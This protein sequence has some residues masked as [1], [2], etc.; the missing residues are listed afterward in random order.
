I[1]QENPSGVWDD[2]FKGVWHLSEDPTGTIYD[3]TLNNNDGT[4]YGSM[5]SG[6]QVSGKIDGSLEFDGD[7]DYIDCGNDNSL[8]ITGDITIEF[9]VNGTSFSNDL[10]PDIL[11]KGNYTQAYST[12]IN[13]D[14]AV[15]FQLNG[16]SFYSTS[17]L[18]L[19]VWHS[20]VCVRNGSD[21]IIY[22]NGNED[23][24]D[25]FSSA[26]E[27]I[28]ETLTIAR[29]PDNL[30]GTLD[31][32]RLS[33]IARSSDWIATEYNNQYN[34]SN[35]S[36]IGTEKT[37]LAH[38]A[39]YFAYYKVITI[40][41]TKVSGSSDLINFPILLSIFDS[42]LH[43]H[44]QVDGDDIAFYSEGKWLDHEIEIFNHSFS[45]TQ[46]HLVTWIR[47]P[48]LSSSIDTEIRMY[49]GNSTMGSQENSNGVWDPNFVGVW[50]LNESGTGTANEYVD[51]GHYGNHGQGGL[52]NVSY[53]P[54][55]TIG[56]I[57]FGQDF[58]DNFIDCGN[59]TS[60]DIT[61]NQITMQLW[62]KYPATHPWMG[63]FNH[64]GYNEGYRLVIDEN[65]Q[66]LSFQLP[67]FESDLETSQ[68]IST[69]EW[70]YVVATYNGS[71]MR[72]YID[73]IPDP[74]NLTK[75]NN[76][77]TALP[78]PFRI[79]HGDHPE[80]VPWSYPWLGQIDEVRIS[81]IGRSA[82]WIATEYNN[83]Y[84]PNS[85]YTIGSQIG[86]DTTPPD[87]TINSPNPNE[88]FGFSAP[89]YNLTVIDA[90]LDS[91]WYSLNGGS[92]STPVGAIGAVD[93]TMWDT[94]GNGTVTIRFYAN[95]TL[96]YLNYDEVTVRKDIINPSIIIN[97][98]TSGSNHS[99]PPSYSL[100]ITEA[101][102]DE[103]WYTLDGGLNN[104]TGAS[105]GI[106]DSTAWGNAGLGA[107]TITF[108]VNDSV[109]N[110]N[111]TS[112]GITKTSDLS[113]SINTP[114]TDEWF[115]SN[116]D[117]EVDVSGIDRNSIWY[118]IDN[119]VN[120][121]TIT[122]NANQ[123]STWFGAIDSTAWGNADEGLITVKFYLNN[124]FGMVISDS[125][126]INKDSI[127][128]SINNINSPLP[129]AWFNNVPP[130]Y[131]LSITEVNLDEIWYTLDGG[132]TNYTG[133]SSG[134]I[135]STAWSNAD[136]GGVTIIFYINDSAGNWDSAS[137]IINKDSIDPSINNINSPLS[138][139]WFNNVPPDYSLSITEVNLD[140]IWYTLDGGTTNYTG[141]SSGTIDS[142]AWSNAD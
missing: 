40:N 14:G 67:G 13:D 124:T 99:T 51:S 68:T 108:Y 42:D 80:G 1:S 6:D 139:A 131:S 54:D 44:A 37:T 104:Y 16:D 142:T 103:I 56:A 55:R 137:V 141:A 122:N 7:N 132:T 111:F 47:I 9:W 3:S 31:E 127:D 61:T 59:A 21:R 4:T 102:L 114:K 48:S 2:N 27:T 107:L 116:P 49:Y 90:N 69:D 23:T 63:P 57:G 113:I 128:P 70:H 86:D 81:N 95:D 123:S 76:I 117:F 133:A 110:W 66:Y 74:A 138:G 19:G 93:E 120:N 29:S 121:Y 78:Y 32:I 52:G 58:V 79:G 130:D 135:D 46:A 25:S 94:L 83:H 26:I 105:S 65:S 30:N 85:F 50:H 64:K 112:V 53:V 33:N 71:L 38:N 5:S 18:S 119:G 75:L 15:Y 39:N 91:I 109:G 96:G 28:T 72:I 17:K 24:S 89:T 87:I 10:D 73:G 100:S 41:S 115:S 97:S 45:G 125:L 22:I 11:T 62:M 88:L 82:D 35:F 8:D 34:P 77:E 129:G 12:W 118:T 126:Q 106:V 136:E 84:N 20:V 43:D 101:N 92:N 60:L 140:E 98:P 36:S 134:T